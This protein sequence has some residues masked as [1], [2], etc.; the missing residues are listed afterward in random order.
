METST[1]VDVV[2]DLINR[3]A[4]EVVTGAE[5]DPLRTSRRVNSAKA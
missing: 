4:M 3:I 5:D 1:L 2:M